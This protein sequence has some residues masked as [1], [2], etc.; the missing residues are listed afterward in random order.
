MTTTKRKIAIVTGGGSGLGFAFAE[1]YVQNGIETIIAGRDK[2]KLDAAKEKLGELCHA[3][4]CNVA[5]L[6]S[7]PGFVK[8]VVDKFGQVYILVNKAGINM[9]KNF[10]EVTD[11]DFE[12]YSC[13]QCNGCV[14]T[15]PGSGEMHTGKTLRQYH[16]YQF[17]GRTIWPSE[18]NCLQRQQNRHRWHDKSNGC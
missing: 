15:K 11:E 2:L 5:D 10:T 16:Q 17:H 9:K 14:Y 6:A 4:P 8:D 12:K 18:S 3:M 7:I 13:H 1:K